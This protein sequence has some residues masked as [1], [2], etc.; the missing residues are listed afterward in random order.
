LIPNIQK[1]KAKISLVGEVFLTL[2]GK[3]GARSTR[4]SEKDSSSTVIYVAAPI[5]INGK[6]TGVITVGKP[7]T[8]INIF[9]RDAKKKVIHIGVIA[10]FSIIIF[11]LIVVIWLTRPIKKLTQ[12]AI[13][14]RK[15]KK[16][17]LPILD[18]SEIGQMGKAFEEMREALEGKKYVEH[19]V[20]N[21]THEIKSPLAAI[22]GA[23]ELL[24]EENMPI[25]HRIKFLKNIQNESARIQQIID[26]MLELSVLE[27]QDQLQ[28][29]EEVSISKLIQE[30]TDNVKPTALKRNL[31]I[32]VNC[33]KDWFIQGDSFLLQ[34][35]ISNLI[36]NAIEFSFPEN[37]IERN[38]FCN[39]A[40]L[41]QCR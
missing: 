28:S 5:Q 23:S 8:N 13:D 18:Q 33:Q 24:E 29:L 30:I 11:S 14:I 9:V 1:M 26:R 41:E 7:T 25:Q 38:A 32:K 19:Y 3:Y 17:I 10:I 12:Y 40:S 21:L 22:R 4:Q 6:I 36:Q 16:A 39:P 35:A 37:K 15:G 31:T 20:Q 27:S 34:Q 2:R